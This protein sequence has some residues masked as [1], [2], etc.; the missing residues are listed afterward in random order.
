VSAPEVR[1]IG[2]GP[3]A[4]ATAAYL[5][6]N[7]VR[8]Q[9]YG[10]VMGFWHGMPTGMYLRSYRRASNIA[11][12]D[13]ALTLPAFESAIGRP[14]PIP[15]PLDD[16]MAYGHWFHEQL[17]V[18]VDNRRVS[19]LATAS[20]G[21]ALTLDDGET[22]TAS[23]VVVA[24]GITPFPWMAPPF[25]GA[26]P[27]LVSHTSE[28]RTYEGWGGKRAV[29]VGAGQSAL[30]AAVWLHE[31]GA[32]TELI[33]RRPSL[34]YLR[35]E[36]LYETGS[37]ASNILYPSWGV[38]PPGVNWLMGRPSIFR[39]IP[40][41]VAEPLARRAIRPAGASWLQ[42]RLDGV[43]ITTGTRVTSVHTT[44]SEATLELSDGTRRTVDHVIVGT[45]YRFDLGRYDFIDRGLLDQIRLKGTY[46]RLSSSFESSVSNLYFVGAAAAA[47]AGPG[48][49]FV[50][51]TDFVASAI[52]RHVA[53][54]R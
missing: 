16:F 18:P 6:S 38:G 13:G 50:S 37:R 47:S 44:D 15:I 34:R 46:P 43:R 7:D 52:A 22:V 53:Q 2:A 40:R 29:V 28:H 41:P 31:V 19:R 32:E 8:T 5:K 42:P 33:V 12:P 30:E 4:L 48:M 11:D 45:G 27:A 14:I 25:A 26:D 24:V 36:K 17:G 21:F 20:D 54:G 10:E 35:G 49:R 9:L 1:I 23:R 3:Y 51:H 39:L